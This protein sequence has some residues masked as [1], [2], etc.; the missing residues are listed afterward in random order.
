MELNNSTQPVRVIFA[1][2]AILF[3]VV[4]IVLVLVIHSM[5][6]PPPWLTTIAPAIGSAVAIIIGW[7]GAEKT[8]ANVWPEPHV[9]Q[10]IADAYSD[11]Y[12]AAAH[13]RA[14]GELIGTSTDVKNAF[15]DDAA[16]SLSALE[17]E[18]FHGDDVSKNDDNIDQD[19]LDEAARDA[20][21]D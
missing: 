17:A 14:V 12:D 10:K 2:V 4:G 8:H 5:S 3:A 21:L 20:G 19:E 16:H 18:V 7:V 15:A 11:A 9:K 1:I 13:D 6:S